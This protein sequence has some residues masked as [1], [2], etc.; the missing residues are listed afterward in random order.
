VIRVKDED[1]FAMGKEMARSEGILAGT[2]SGAAA[3]AAVEVA[4]RTESQGKNIV[5]LLPDTGERYL[6]TPLFLC[7]AK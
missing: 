7:K 3:W 1:A 6:S 4:K 5:V 2:S